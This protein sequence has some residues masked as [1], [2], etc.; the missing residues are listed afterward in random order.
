MHSVA[1]FAPH[2]LVTLSRCEQRLSKYQENYESNIWAVA[3]V[4]RPHASHTHDMFLKIHKLAKMF[5]MRVLAQRPERALTK[6]RRWKRSSALH[7]RDSA[8]DAPSSDAPSS[9]ESTAKDVVTSAWKIDST[10]RTD[11]G[12]SRQMGM[13]AASFDS[14]LAEGAAKL[15]AA[16]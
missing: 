4:R 8:H 3:F 14:A 2:L 15:S 5:S 12:Q 7:S 6:S 13:P 1:L 11:I 9:Y 16:F 10:G